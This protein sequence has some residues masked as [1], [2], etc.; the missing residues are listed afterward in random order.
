MTEPNWERLEDLLKVVRDAHAREHFSYRTYFRNRRIFGDTDPLNAPK[1]V[2]EENWCDTTACLAGHAIAY[3]ENQLWKTQ[4]DGTI[5]I[6][7]PPCV[8]DFAT[9]GGEL[10]SLDKTEQNW[11]FCAFPDG[12]TVKRGSLEVEFG[13]HL[14]KY[15][16][17]SGKSVEDVGLDYLEYVIGRRKFKRPDKFIKMRLKALRDPG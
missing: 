6:E 3:W 12:E 17:K 8:G 16:N 13:K 15:L 7:W 1:D 10:L 11:L 4:P 14:K 9:L 2:R 5:G